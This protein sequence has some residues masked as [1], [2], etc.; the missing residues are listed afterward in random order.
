MP[1]LN[2][3]SEFIEA[4]I[5]QEKAVQSTEKA[6]KTDEQKA[7]AILDKLCTTNPSNPHFLKARAWSLSTL[8][9]EEDAVSSII[10]AQYSEMASRLSGKNDVAK[11]W[12]TELET[13]KSK[14]TAVGESKVS[15]S[16][17]SFAA[18]AMKW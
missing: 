5:L 13:L 9:R 17:E 1:N 2:E 3:W 6:S 15:A 7:L 8:D 12:I 16:N 14:I 11:N 10:E 18:S 4:R